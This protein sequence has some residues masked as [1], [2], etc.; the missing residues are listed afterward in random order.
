VYVADFPEQCLVARCKESRCPWCKVGNKRGEPVTSLWRETDKTV[1]LLSQDQKCKANHQDL[2]ELFVELG[3]HTVYEPFWKALP[4]TDIFQTFTPD[5]LHQLH[6]GIFKDHLVNWCTRVVSA[7]ELDAQ[8]KAMNGH[9][10]LRHFKKGI[11]FILQWTGR[12]HKQIQRIFVGVMA[13]A[14]NDQVLMVVRSVINFIYYSQFHRHTTQTLAAL[15]SCLDTFHANKNI[16]VKLGIQEHF[17]IPKLHMI[18]H[19]I[20]AILAHGSTDGYN[21]ESPEQFHID[22]AKKAYQASNKH[23]FLEQMALWL[24]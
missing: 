11:S 5:L 10:S 3:L 24:Q 6:K 15:Q 16:L 14:V 22:L 8:F 20:D 2:A 9:A 1:Q 18:Q 19:Y 23:D 13:G 12:E 4:H 21:T 17:N 7:A